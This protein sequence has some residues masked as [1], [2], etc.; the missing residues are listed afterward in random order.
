[1]PAASRT[2]GRSGTAPRPPVP[3]RGTPCTRGCP[4]ASGGAARSWPARRR[5][6]GVR[7]FRTLRSFAYRF[8]AHGQQP[9]GADD[10]HEEQDQ[11]RRG[12]PVLVVVEAQAVGVNV[13][14]LDFVEGSTALAFG[15]VQD[16]E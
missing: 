1:M 15:G 9:H 5:P 6:F 11:Y 4:A 8:L 3:P 12:Q 7:C 13:E 16:V 2:A 10:D 14:S